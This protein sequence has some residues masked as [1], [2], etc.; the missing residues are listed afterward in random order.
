MARIRKTLIDAL[1]LK[2][3]LFFI[4]VIKDETDTHDCHD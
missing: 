4:G 3:V 1:F 2:T